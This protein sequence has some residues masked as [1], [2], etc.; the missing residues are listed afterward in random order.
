MRRL[1]REEWDMNCVRSLIEVEGEV[2][3]VDALL[4]L[5][6]LLLLELDVWVAVG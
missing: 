1:E 2:L 6:L 5:L 3:V 4:L